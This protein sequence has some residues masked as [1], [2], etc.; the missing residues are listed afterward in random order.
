MG[1]AVFEL[2]GVVPQ[3]LFMAAS[4]VRYE[5]F[6]LLRIF[7]TACMD[8]KLAGGTTCSLY[9]RFRKNASLHRSDPVLSGA[10][11]R[12]PPVG[13]FHG[14]TAARSGEARKGKFSSEKTTGCNLDDGKALLV[15]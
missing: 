10:L 5:R 13:S 8:L 12:R 3:P 6:P 1:I 14:R 9:A 2:S 4:Y 15:M 11:A 7:K